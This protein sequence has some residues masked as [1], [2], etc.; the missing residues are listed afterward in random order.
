MAL[1]A[2]HSA[3]LQIAAASAEAMSRGDY[4]LVLG[5][6]HGGDNPLAQGVF[7][8]AIPIPVR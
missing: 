3:D 8:R 5:D 1:S 4:L 2:Y 6:F 7:A